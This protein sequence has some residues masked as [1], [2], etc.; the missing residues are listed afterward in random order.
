MMQQH[1]NFNFEFSTE[2]AQR[3]QE[4]LFAEA[5]ARVREK[6]LQGNLHVQ[7]GDGPIFTRP[8]TDLSKLNENHWKWQD[9][10]S[11][12]GLP[13][14]A[15]LAMI[16]NQYRRLARRYHPDKSKLPDTASRFQ[17]V[18]E[19]YHNLAQRSTVI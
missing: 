1:K 13:R 4:R 12:L 2:A 5:A 8:V 11:R 9:P 3:E 19:A 6:G 10:Y 14:G 17:A 7:S 15:S 16:K 18:T